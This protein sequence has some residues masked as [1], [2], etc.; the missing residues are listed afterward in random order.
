R[1]PPRPGRAARRDPPVPPPGQFTIHDNLPGPK[2]LLI[3]PT[4][5]L[6]A[7]HHDLAYAQAVKRLFATERPVT[8]TV[9]R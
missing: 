6:G 5:H 4:G 3:L 1:R 7:T 2:E 8:A 9:R